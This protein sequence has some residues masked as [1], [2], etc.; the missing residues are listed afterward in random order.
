ML[1]WY[2][3][4]GKDSDVVISSRIRL[5][6]N[7]S[8]FPFSTKT[9]KQKENEIINLLEE[10]TQKIG[11]GLK[12]LKLKDIDDITKMSLVEK[13]L[14]SPEFALNKTESGAILINDDEN[15]CIM[16]NEEDHLRIQIFNAGLDIENVIN[17]SIELDEKIGEILPY[18]YN[19]QYGFLTSC[20]TNVGTG[21]RAS[22]MVHLPALTKTGNIRKILDIVNNFG[23]NIR[24]IYG[25]GSNTQGNVYQISNQQSLG[26]SEKDIIKNLKIIK[27]KII[28]QERLARKYLS[29]NSIDL[30]DK[31][32][33]AYG[34]LANC[35]KI[36]SE[37]CRQLLSDIR[38]GTDLGIIDE[39]NDLKVNKL[40]LYTKPAN[41]QKYLSKKIDSYERDIRRAEVI[42]QIINE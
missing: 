11:Y 39:L 14:I 27:E 38:L 28:E 8:D 35:K 22:I 31:V 32:Y 9:T 7:L 5:A 25:E 18:A 20:P 34:I 10:N 2:L 13:H 1:N 24:G 29:K 4:S 19:E 15:I 36:T 30:E 37:E 21:L 41:L 17:L 12:L 40:E 23:M 16:I 3:Q 33:R 6:R 42:K 26:I